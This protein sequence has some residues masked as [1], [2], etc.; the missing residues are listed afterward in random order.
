[1]SELAKECLYYRARNNLTQAEMAK[2][3]GIDRTLIIEIE[4]DRYV[5]RMTEAKV[6]IVIDTEG[7]ESG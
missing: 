3:C 7:T 2:R 4:H 1:M 6:R 5:S